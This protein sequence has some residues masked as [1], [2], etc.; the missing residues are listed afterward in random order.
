VYTVRDRYVRPG[1]R[2]VDG[3]LAWFGESG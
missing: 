1:S 2:I 3:K